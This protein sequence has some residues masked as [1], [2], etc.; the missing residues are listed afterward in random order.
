MLVIQ[1]CSAAET[2]TSLDAVAREAGAR[3]DAASDPDE[4]AEAKADFDEA[5]G[6]LIDLEC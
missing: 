4:I 3:Y 1:A 6:K 2:C 5:V